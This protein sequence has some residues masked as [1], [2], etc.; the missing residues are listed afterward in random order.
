MSDLQAAT[1]AVPADATPD[2]LLA[3][4][5]CYLHAARVVVGA[6]ARVESLR[7]HAERIRT[8]LAAGVSIR[9]LDSPQFAEAL[10]RDADE[11]ERDPIRQWFGTEPP[12]SMGATWLWPHDAWRPAR[13]ATTNVAIAGAF[14]ARAVSVR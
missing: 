9:R 3:A 2:Q 10:D 5:Q 4:A 14:A 6:P 1:A 12:S 8:R 7:A 13:S 11:I